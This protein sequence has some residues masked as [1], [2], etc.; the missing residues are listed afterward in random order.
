MR[1][2]GK[3][4]RAGQEVRMADIPADAGAGLGIFQNLHGCASGAELADRLNEAV[5]QHHGTA[6]R[7]FIWHLT[8]H[9][10][11]Q[12]KGGIDSLRREFLSEFL[13]AGVDGQSRR[14][15]GRFAL[16]AAA[17]ELATTL[18]VTGWPPGTASD[19]AAQCF[20]AWLDRRGGTDNREEVEALATVKH[21]V[22][23]HGES[24]FTD[25]DTDTERVTIHR[26]GFRRKVAGKTQ[27]LFLPEVFKRE[28]CVG[29]DPQQVLRTLRKVGWLVTEV[30]DRFTVKT[31]AHGRVYVVQIH[32]D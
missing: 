28:V 10:P 11:E 8:Q 25:E 19:A 23:A 12:I 14:V 17:G 16:V 2:A 24:R 21:F 7:A 29:L 3:R 26:A 18:G 15:G 31:R 1:E 30:P 20:R 13:P 5:R 22:E 4:V 9:P 27:Y 32:E 6:A